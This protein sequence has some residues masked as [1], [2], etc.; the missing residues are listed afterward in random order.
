MVEYTENMTRKKAEEALRSS[1]DK[2]VNY[3]DTSPFYG[4]GRSESFLGRVLSRV[5]RDK[6]Y[7]GTKVGRYFWDVK[8]RFDFSRETILKGFEES[9]KRLQLEHVDILQL[10][11]VEFAPSLDII[12]NEAL[13]AIQELK[14]KGF[15]RAIGITGYPIGP[16]KEIIAHSHHI[17]IDSVLSYARLTLNDNSLK[18]H[19]DFFKSHGVSIINAS[20]VSMGLLTSEGP[21]WWNPA[22]PYIKDKCKEAV[23]YCNSK[24]VDITRLAVNYSTS[25]DE[26]VTTLVTIS[27]TQMLDR[28]LSAVLSPMTEKEKKVAGDLEKF[29]SRLPQRHWEG[30]ELKEYWEQIGNFK[31]N[32]Q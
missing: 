10:H 20:P 5:P 7:I 4:E 17:K 32:N 18:D 15:C 23:E 12:M 14:D 31:T 19:F 16:L 21:Q 8:K 1:L 27:D 30:V 28:N 11:D 3:I 22:L 6:Y 26:V 2:G 24:G 9:L 25:F 29:F 13:P